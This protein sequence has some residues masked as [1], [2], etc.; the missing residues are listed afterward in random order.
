MFLD[1]LVDANTLPL[2]NNSPAAV[3]RFILE[4][5]PLPEGCQ[6]YIG[7]ENK[8]VS[9]EEYLERGGPRVPRQRS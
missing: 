2:Y 1:C 7:S 5:Q 3:R 6:V 4:S 8:I 9:I